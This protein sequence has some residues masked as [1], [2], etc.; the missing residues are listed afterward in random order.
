MA[1]CVISKEKRNELSQ[2]KPTNLY[3]FSSHLLSG[4]NFGNKFV[5]SHYP[6]NQQQNTIKIYKMFKNLF[7]IQ[8]AHK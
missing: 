6:T 7:Q 1:N 3:G 5:A 4:Q 2:L 8:S